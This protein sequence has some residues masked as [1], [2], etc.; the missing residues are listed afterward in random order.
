MDGGRTL[1]SLCPLSGREE[2]VGGPG[3]PRGPVGPGGPS[4]GRALAGGGP[5]GEKPPLLI[6]RER[7]ASTGTLR[8]SVRMEKIQKIQVMPKSEFLFDSLIL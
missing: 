2:R 1:R 5:D 7:T 4:G 8:S 3:P 6:G